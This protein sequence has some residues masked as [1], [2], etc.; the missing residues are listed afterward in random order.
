VDDSGAV[1]AVIRQLVARVE[2]RET[3]AMVVASDALA[4]FRVLSFPRDASDANIDAHVRSQLPL[5]CGRMGV[6]RQEMTSNGGDSTVNAVAYDRAKIQMLAA[7]LRLAGLE[8]AV[9]ELKSL[10][11]A[12][13]AQPPACVVVDIADAGEV[14]VVDGGLPRLWHS[15]RA[16]L[17]V[18]EELAA[19]VIYALRTALNFYRR[20]PEGASFSQS[21]PILIST[22]HGFSSRLAESLEGAV[23]HPVSPLPPSP[24]VPPEIRQGSFMACLGLIMRRR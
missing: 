13:V 4:S 23:G 2:I 8:P 18:P 5:E 21:A 19:S 15:F 16:D 24:R 10:C 17:Q 11:V 14:F 1:A 9:V 12:R 22:D 3:R 6:H 20:Q 7:T